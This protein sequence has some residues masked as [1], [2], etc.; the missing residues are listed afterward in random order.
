LN[1]VCA[2]DAS[3]VAALYAEMLVVSVFLA[4]TIWQAASFLI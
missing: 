3:A 4:T 2:A 1:E